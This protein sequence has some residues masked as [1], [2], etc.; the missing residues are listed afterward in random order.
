MFWAM[1]KVQNVVDGIDL[2]DK[3]D[4]TKRWLCSGVLPGRADGATRQTFLCTRASNTDHPILAHVRE[5]VEL[6]CAR[7]I[8]RTVDVRLT[9]HRSTCNFENVQGTPLRVKLQFPQCC[10]YI[11]PW[12]RWKLPYRGGW[13]A[14]RMSLSSFPAKVSFEY[15]TRLVG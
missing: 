12:I 14:L 2:D 5:T 8:I 15:T 10:Y 11:Q 13:Q 7:S 3:E 4:R 1:V 9:N 6:D